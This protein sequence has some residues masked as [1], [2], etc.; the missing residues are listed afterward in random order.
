MNNKPMRVT[1]NI[2]VG[3][4]EVLDITVKTSNLAT[5]LPFIENAMKDMVVK[6]E[7]TKQNITFR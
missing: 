7:P 6:Q 5:L 1:L 3:D 4:E 2:T